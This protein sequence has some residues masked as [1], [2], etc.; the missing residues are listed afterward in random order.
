MAD[1]NYYDILGVDKNASQEEIKAS[2]R[3]LVKQYHP[4]LHPGDDSCAA[5]FKEINEANEVLSDSQ[6]RQQYDFE[7]EHPSFK[8]GF[9]SEGADFSDFG[10][11]FSTI[12]GGFG[13]GGTQ[14]QTKKGRDLTY[15]F[16][17]SFLDAALGCTKEFSY[18]RK[19]RCADCHGT[20]AKNGT[21][22]KQC[23]KCGGTGQLKFASGTGMFRTVTTR[24]CDEC[25]GT[26]KII[27]ENCPIC[28]GRGT[29][30]VNTKVKFDIPSGA[31]NDSYI[32]RKGYGE[33]PDYGGEPGDLLIYFKVKPH[34]IFKRKNFDLYVTVPIS[35]KTACFGGKVLIPSLDKPFEYSIPEGIQGGKVICIK[36]KGIKNRNKYGDMFVTV[37]VETPVKLSH[38]QKE[39]I[40]RLCDELENKQHPLMNS[41]KDNMG[42]DFGVDP[43]AVK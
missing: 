21:A 9:S 8:G 27:T 28:K 33:T 23:S 1:K 12:F 37:Q 15:E 42:K 24:L 39:E 43:Y 25:R 13:G 2:Y 32:R 18:T 36:G 7:L 19:D 6:K 14:R 41:Y 22:L 11:I 34:K 31:D 40:S 20:G 3:K 10:D 30:M 29:A 4:D 35:F 38:K 26:G 16:E 17:L 5:K